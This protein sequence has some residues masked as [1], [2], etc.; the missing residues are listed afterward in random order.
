MA[1]AAAMARERRAR[2]ESA[3]TN[4]SPLTR[5]ER[6]AI[7]GDDDDGGQGACLIRFHNWLR[8]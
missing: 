8:S 2:L 3:F 6:E 1:I 4:F 7:D 5:E